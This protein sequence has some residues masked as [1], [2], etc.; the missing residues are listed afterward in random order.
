MTDYMHVSLYNTILRDAAILAVVCAGALAAIL[1]AP[2]PP[3]PG[4]SIGSYTFSN[5][6]TGFSLYAGGN[7]KYILFTPQSKQI[8]PTIP[9]IINIRKRIESIGLYLFPTQP[10]RT[11]SGT[12][13]AIMEHN[14]INFS[15]TDLNAPL[16]I[17]YGRDDIVILNEATLLTENPQDLVVTLQGMYHRTFTQL[18][19]AVRTAVMPLASI[20]IIKPKVAGAI[21]IALPSMTNTRFDKDTRT[22]I[23]DSVDGIQATVEKSLNNL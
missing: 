7:H 19:P 8:S 15:S 14:R 17:E 6:G 16:H 4:R 11:Q 2:S 3:N 1:A 20:T 23:L 12:T 9:M 21:Q 18:D 10:W 13:E 5:T 22:I